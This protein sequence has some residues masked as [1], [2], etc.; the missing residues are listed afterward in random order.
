MP[1]NWA[2]KR[3]PNGRKDHNHKH[4]GRFPRYQNQTNRNRGA[5]ATTVPDPIFRNR[6]NGPTWKVAKSSKKDRLYPAKRTQVFR[7]FSRS[8]PTVSQGLG[9]QKKAT[10]IKVAFRRVKIDGVMD[11]YWSVSSR[12]RRSKSSSSFWLSEGTTDSGVVGMVSTGGIST[13]ASK[14][15]SC[16]VPVSIP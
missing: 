3:Q 1:A 9:Q 12:I 7:L 14:V 11:I 10:S 13:G 8:L 16:V 5:L 2:E 15:P 6:P 4:L